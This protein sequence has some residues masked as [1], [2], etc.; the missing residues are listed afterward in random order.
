V[1][2]WFSSDPKSVDCTIG[3]ID[4]GWVRCAPTE[5]QAS[6]ASAFAKPAEV[7]YDLGHVVSVTKV[8]T[9]R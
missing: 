4:A 8:D 6:A 2:L 1:R 7:W 3:R 5:D 9:Q